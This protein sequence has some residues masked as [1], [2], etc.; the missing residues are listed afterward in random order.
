[1][2]C[3]PASRLSSMNGCK[4][5]LPR[6]GT[7]WPSFPVILACL[8]LLAAHWA[9]A[10]T[11]GP[12]FSPDSRRY[13]ANSEQLLHAEN[14][15]HSSKS[16]HM[17]IPLKLYRG[18]EFL[19][20]AAK[21]V[22]HGNW[23]WVILLLNLTA[24]SACAFGL[25]F[26]TYRLT[27]SNFRALS[28][29]VLLLSCPDIA[30]W[31]SFVLTDTIFTTAAFFFFLL[32]LR[33]QPGSRFIVTWFVTG[34]LLSILRPTGALFVTATA[35]GFAAASTTSP[36]SRM[37]LQSTLLLSGAIAVAYHTYLILH[38]AAWPIDFAQEY[39]MM[40]VDD[41]RGGVVVHL[42]G[43]TYLP[44]AHDI[45]STMRISLA[46]FIRFFQV[47]ADGYSTSH[48]WLSGGTLTLIFLGAAWEFVSQPDGL[49]TRRRRAFTAGMTLALLVA[50]FHALTQLDFDWRYR[51]PLLP[52][53]I[54]L[55]AGAGNRILGTK[56]AGPAGPK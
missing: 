42:R 33:A 8:L 17:G 36:R 13:D 24:L 38:P 4:S 52:I 54:F 19:C 3:E 15:K 7:D 50:G 28:A 31:T 49:N 55:A 40:V 26:E 53:L 16:T 46:K 21:V 45:W 5:G 29:G 18:F 56:T 1:M 35:L 25:V 51:T 2:S 23:P 14:P 9:L 44:P 43:E 22:A 41:Y 20:A 11:V 10:L 47:S 6:I 12:R 48:K 32:T 27:A 30:L 37:A 39:F 34:A